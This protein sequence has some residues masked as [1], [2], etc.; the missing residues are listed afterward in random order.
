MYPYI[1]IDRKIIVSSFGSTTHLA[2][3]LQKNLLRTNKD[4]YFEGGALV[5]WCSELFWVS[6]K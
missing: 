5:K 4:H 2:D 1:K 3:I 6:F